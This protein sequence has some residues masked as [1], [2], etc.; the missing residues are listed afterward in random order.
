MEL[1][2]D[3]QE[4]KKSLLNAANWMIDPQIV[5][6][7]QVHSRVIQRQQH[8][9]SRK[10]KKGDIAGFVECIGSRRGPLISRT[11][12]NAASCHQPQSNTDKVTKAEQGANTQRL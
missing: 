11:V 1:S 9:D 2:T 6:T 5:L 10:N 4:K 7:Y 12:V 8:Y 3:L